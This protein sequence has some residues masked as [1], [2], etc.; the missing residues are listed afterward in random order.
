MRHLHAAMAHR[1]LM[2][3]QH[4]N[5]ACWLNQLQF[6]AVGTVLAIELAFAVWLYVQWW[7]G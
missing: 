7:L 4:C 2:A 6:V 1:V 5:E 3:H